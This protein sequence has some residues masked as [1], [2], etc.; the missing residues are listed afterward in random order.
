VKRFLL[1]LTGSL[2]IV[3]AILAPA[4]GADPAD[5]TWLLLAGVLAVIAA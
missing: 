5:C 1:A 3:G 4:A 2:V